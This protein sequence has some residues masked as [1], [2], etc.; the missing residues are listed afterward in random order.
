MEQSEGLSGGF[1][2]PANFGLALS[3]V[4]AFP[5]LAGNSLSSRFPDDAVRLHG[6]D[7][8][9]EVGTSLCARKQI[10]VQEEALYSVLTAF[11]YWL[12]P[13]RPLT[14]ELGEP[15]DAYPQLW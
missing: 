5:V 9:A 2:E 7:V 8:R 6:R 14:L 11:L 3:R 12:R 15:D 1:L 4:N 13:P 10:S